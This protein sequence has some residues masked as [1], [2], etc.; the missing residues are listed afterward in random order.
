MNEIESVYSDL[1][2]N[3]I[4]FQRDVLL[5]KYSHTKTGGVTPLIVYPH[6]ISELKQS[7][8]LIQNAH[9]E[10]YVLGDMTNVA[11]ASGSLS[12]VVIDMNEYLA[13]PEY[14][15]GILTVSAGY[16]MKELSRWA[17]HQSISG[18][19][20]M[21]GIPGT[22]GAGVCMNA[23]FL[24]G[25]D[26]Q[27]I[28]ISAD[29]LL[30]NL[31]IQTIS[32]NEMNYSYRKSIIQTN[33]GIVLSAKL[34]LRRGKKW[35]INLRMAQY[36]HRRAKNQPLE[37][38]SAGT[39]FIPPTPYH[40]GGMLPALGLVGHR[41][42]GAEISPKSPGFIVGVDNM[43]GED[44]YSEVRFIQQQIKNHYNIN[45]EPEVRLLGFKQNE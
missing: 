39:V 41:T 45:L 11:I 6:N 5:Q 9:V 18:L 29:V 31:S 32:N 21:E 42:G 22:V 19:A 37:L 34:L 7:V 13:E 40:L 4:K 16:K 25:Q 24:S 30:P 33:G 43:T 26:F 28:L 36:H 20:W 10:Y 8:S 44:Y 1:K 17:L 14:T 23:G 38:P 15:D 3:K 12:F 2:K 27:S 35:K